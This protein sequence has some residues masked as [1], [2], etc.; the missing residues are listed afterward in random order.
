MDNVVRLCVALVAGVFLIGPMCV[1][2]VHLSSTK[3]LVTAS[4]CT[5]LFACGLS[6]GIKSSNVETLVATATYSA[7]LV[8][9]VGSNL[10]TSPA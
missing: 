4:V 1:M 10:G 9:F 2:S 7:V 3:S 5:V 6:F 8:V